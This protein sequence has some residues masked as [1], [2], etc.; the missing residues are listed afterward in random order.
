LLGLSAVIEENDGA[1]SYWALKHSLGPPDF[2]DASA[3][4]LE[5]EPH[6][7]AVLD[8]AYTDKR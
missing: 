8:P 5:W 3:F 6:V 1:V 4:I 2:H 7:A